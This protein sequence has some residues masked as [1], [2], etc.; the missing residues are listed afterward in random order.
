MKKT[1]IIYGELKTGIQER[2]VEELSRILL[3]Y[4]NEY[5]I[6]IKYG[7]NIDLDAYR[8]IFIGTKVTNPYVAINSK[9]DLTI[10]ESYSI[11]VSN[12]TVM[13]EGYDDAGV[14]YGVLDFYNKYVIKYEHKKPVPTFNINHTNLWEKEALIDFEM[15]SA[16]AVRE[17]G[18]WTWGHVIYDYRDYLRNMMLLKMNAVIIWNDFV[19]TNAKQIVEYAH[20]C[21]IKVYWGFAWLWDTGVK[22]SIDNLENE[23]KK[24]FEKYEAEYANSN[25]DGIYFQT[26]TEFTT[27]N[28][29][30]I[31][32]AE[33]AAKFVNDTSALLYAKYPELEIQF[34]LHA[35]SVNNKLE[36]IQSVDP[37]IRII[38]EDC[39]SIPFDYDPHN[40][41]H[42]D[43]TME[44]MGRIANLRGENDRFGAVT[45][46]F[47]NLDWSNFKHLEGS[48]CI[49]ISTNRMKKKRTDGMSHQWRYIQAGWLVNADK[50]RLMVQRMKQL[51]N[52]D[53]SILALVE[54]GMFED[55]IKYP[56]ALYA[57]MLWD[58]D[59]TIGNL[60]KY[61][62]LRSYVDFV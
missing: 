1:A 24:I 41:S 17:R 58:C 4:L 9:A 28:L 12:D 42:F 8:C 20:S 56:V 37:R 18:L 44:F 50:A 30:G 61:V 35:T 43:E 29:D 59:N 19:P 62:A 33:A 6:C 46:G 31:V 57:E 11:T 26:F 45:K 15:T 14:L 3:D 39:G 49:G 47:V 32:I 51:K 36:F 7:E 53:L 34:G 25:G 55:S 2:A 23:P 5:P 27:D 40:A 48:Q 52:G 60:M 10:P 54:D 13:I 16:P 22:I 38:W 21:N